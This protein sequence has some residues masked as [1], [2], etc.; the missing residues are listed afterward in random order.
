MARLI[1]RTLGVA[2]IVAAIAHTFGSLNAYAFLSTELVWAISASAF[3]IL[4][5]A[6]NMLRMNRPGDHTLAW[7]C[8]VGCVAWIV[9]ALSFNVSIGHVADPRGLIH[10]I[11][12][13]GLAFF[14]FRSATTAEAA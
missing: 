14:S 7:I 12:T 10:A 1:D 8:F 3:A 5:A 6:I 13:A 9:L 4:I 11:V 2:L